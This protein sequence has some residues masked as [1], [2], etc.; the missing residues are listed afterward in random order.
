L[1]ELEGALR[2]TAQAV[3]DLLSELLPAPE[4]PEARVL[5]AMRYATLAGGKR[6]RPFL[7][8]STSELFDVPRARALRAGAAIELVHTYSL[9]HDDLP[10]MDDDDLRRGMPTVH[11][12]FDEATA[13]L[14]GDGLLT[15][16]FEV[17]ANEATHENAGVRVELIRRLAEASGC[18]GMVGGQMVDLEA[19]HCQL[20]LAA[21]NHL[22]QLKTGALFG[23]C[24]DAGAILGDAP[25]AA[26]EA[27]RA[28]AADLGLAF[29]IADDLLD[30][31][32][33]AEMMGKNVGKD[34]A[35]GKA[36]FVSLLGL[37][38]AR[39]EA[40]KLVVTADSHLDL[41]GEKADLLRR[42]ARFVI[43][44]QA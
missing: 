21:I 36:T 29:Q 16:A 5:E 32:G 9:V 40:E 2:A 27:L 1:S 43:N 33:T 11:V 13:V 26:R 39:A 3:N 37:D 7:V 14:A 6:L 24:C 8:V 19:E 38:G 28:Y 20:D 25:S 15:H 4:G 23:F 30:A 10:C 35:A 44:R 31:Q 12:K 18:L 22:Q 42:L 41:F 17:L 34:A